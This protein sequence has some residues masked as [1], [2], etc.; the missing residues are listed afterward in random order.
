MAVQR[1]FEE[2]SIIAR[3]QFITKRQENIAAHVEELR[4]YVGDEQAFA[5]LTEQET[6]LDPTISIKREGLE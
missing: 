1:V 2:P 6:S 4:L 3:H 5:L